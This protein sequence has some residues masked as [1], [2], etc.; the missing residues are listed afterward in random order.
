MKLTYFILEKI[1]LYFRQLIP[2]K[3]RVV[4]SLPFK[5]VLVISPHIDDDII[6]AGGSIIKHTSKNGKASVVYITSD[7]QQRVDEASEVSK[8]VN[9][10]KVYFIGYGSDRIK[11][12][13]YLCDKLLEIFHSEK[14][15]IVLLPFLI[16]N[17]KDHIA[18]NELII[19]FADQ[20]HFI[21]EIYAYE[22]WTPIYPNL[23]VDITDVFD[24]KRQCLEI[25]KSQ[26]KTHNYVQQALSLNKFRGSVYDIGY[27][28]A[29]FKASLEYYKFLWS[30]I[31]G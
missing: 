15:E 13:N 20:Y 23:I 31:Y 3:A 24:T 21:F 5:K 4:D 1:F 28:E 18:T 9:Y 26:L 11:Y 30:K 27:A 12:C 16:D 8:I 6:G 25:Y 2:I 19:K 29:F 10:D 22:V 17:H 7:N 14:P